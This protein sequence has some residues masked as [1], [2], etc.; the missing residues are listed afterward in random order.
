MPNSS[1]CFTTIRLKTVR[2]P[3]VVAGSLCYTGVEPKLTVSSTDAACTIPCPGISTNLHAIHCISS[4]GDGSVPCG[5]NE[6][7]R[8]YLYPYVGETQFTSLAHYELIFRRGDPM[9]FNIMRSCGYWL[10]RRTECKRDTECISKICT[11][12]TLSPAC[13]D[14]E[15]ME[16]TARIVSPR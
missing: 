12:R 14:R 8:L 3:L 7:V 2:C 6:N 1:V 9:H 13:V 16:P 11:F 5:D 4:T 15:R 10:L